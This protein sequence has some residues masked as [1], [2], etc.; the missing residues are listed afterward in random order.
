MKLIRSGTIISVLYLSYSRMFATGI[1][2]HFNKRCFNTYASIFK[3]KKFGPNLLNN[4]IIF[5]SSYRN[6]NDNDNDNDKNKKKIDYIDAEIVDEKYE[7]KY[8]KK[9]TDSSTLSTVSGIFQSAKNKLSNFFKSDNEKEN[10][11]LFETNKKKKYDK[12]MDIIQGNIDE[13]FKNT[14]L[15]GGMFGSIIKSVA[16]PLI[17]SMLESMEES[18]N[19]VNDVIRTAKRALQSDQNFISAL[20]T[21][22]VDLSSPIQSSISSSSFNGVGQT[23]IYLML[24]FEGSYSN[25]FVEVQSTIPTTNNKKIRTINLD[26]VKVRFANG[27]TMIIKTNGSFGNSNII[28]V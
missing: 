7:S 10:V 13:V 27:R 16:K 23:N 17:S 20:G 6:N 9:S 2:N 4:N 24:P 19:D 28:D 18:K 12:E 25:G 11:S 15:V 14:G 8:D 5:M 3:R 1:I 26:S 22:E 21:S